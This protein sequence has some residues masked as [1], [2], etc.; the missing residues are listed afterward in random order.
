MIVATL[1]RALQAGRV[2]D[3]SGVFKNLAFAKLWHRALAVWHGA[4]AQALAWAWAF[5]CALASAN[6]LAFFR[7]YRID[8]RG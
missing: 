6:V 1:K 8:A 7:E 3:P 2:E 5:A 4:L